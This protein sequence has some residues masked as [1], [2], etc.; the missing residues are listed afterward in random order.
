MTVLSALVNGF[1]VE[2]YGFADV[3]GVHIYA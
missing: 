2:K 1:Y 3:G